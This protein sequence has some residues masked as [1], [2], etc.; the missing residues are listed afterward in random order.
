VKL[1]MPVIARKALFGPES[2][3]I[4]AGTHEYL[5]G[6]VMGALCFHEYP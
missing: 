4:A 3:V 2:L 5:L 6:I 1:I